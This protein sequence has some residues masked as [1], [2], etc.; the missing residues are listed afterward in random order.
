MKPL[1][2][3]RNF[4][5]SKARYSFAQLLVFVALLGWSALVPAQQ[6]GWSPIPADELALKDDPSAPGA[7]ALILYRDMVADDKKGVMTEHVRIKILKDEGKKYADIE[8][9]TSKWFKV[10]SKEIEART[11]GPDGSSLPF[12]GE[13]HDKAVVKTR[14]FTIAEKTFTLPDA[15]TGGIIEFR[16]RAHFQKNEYLTHTWDV[17]S[18]LFTRK[19]HFELR[20]TSMDL[21]RVSSRNFQQQPQKN[22]DTLYLDVQNVAALDDEDFTLPKSE[23]RSQVDLFYRPLGLP[24]EAYWGRVSQL[25]GEELN[26]FIGKNKQVKNEVA[27]LT[28]PSDTPETK[29]RKLYTRAQQ[30]RKVN[31]DSVEGEHEKRHENKHAD[32]VLERGYGDIID[33]SALLAAMAREVGYQSGLVFLTDRARGLFHPEVL[34][35][36]QLTA[37]MT[38]VEKDGKFTLLD[39]AC[40]K[41]PYGLIS[42]DQSGAS[43]I[44]TNYSGSVYVHVPANKADDAIFERRGDLKLEANGSLSGSVTLTIGGLEALELRNP[45]ENGDEPGRKKAITELVKSWLPPTAEV[46]LE[47]I[48]NWDDIDK[49]IVAEMAINVPKFGVAT[50]KRLVIPASLFTTRSKAAFAHEQRRYAVVFENPY[51]RTDDMTIAVPAGYQIESVPEGK[52]STSSILDYS[53]QI[54]NK[55]DKIHISRTLTN[56]ALYVPTQYYKQLRSDFNFVKATDEQQ[57]ILRQSTTASR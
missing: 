2:M 30:I 54:Q 48:S 16:Y 14:N 10:D 23:L 46:K 52:G 25:R 53:L 42:W 6:S 57:A 22:R 7:P 31:F 45:E 43:G 12:T 3:L 49:P 32:D 26:E 19:A 15:Q 17:Q 51:R 35:T 44:R 8:I 20:P 28:S 40:Q 21:I 13:I 4:G 33:I 34:S 39:P 37:E 47:R 5:K 56:H 41:C 38:W 50:G 9:P 1:R 18:E 24:E 29:L 36:L 55:G 11:V 27:R